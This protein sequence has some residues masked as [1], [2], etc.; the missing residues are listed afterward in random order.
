MNEN[1]FG[2]S[3]SH[4]TAEAALAEAAQV[5]EVSE[6]L[7]STYMFEGDEHTARLYEADACAAKARAKVIRGLI[8]RRK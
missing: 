1:W 5:V 6:K 2:I 3:K 4:P 8:S 7:A